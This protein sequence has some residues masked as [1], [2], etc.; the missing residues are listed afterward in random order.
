MNASAVYRILEDGHEIV[1]P[2]NPRKIQA[3]EEFLHSTQCKIGL[4]DDPEIP[5][6]VAEVHVKDFM[7]RHSKMLGLTENDVQVMQWLKQDA[8]EKAKQAGFTWKE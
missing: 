1:L 7:L 8:I 6:Q 5:R 4:L 2:A 3:I